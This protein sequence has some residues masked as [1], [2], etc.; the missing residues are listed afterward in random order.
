MKKSILVATIL[1]FCLVC[2]AIPLT[3]GLLVKNKINTTKPDVNI[4]PNKNTKV[5]VSARQYLNSWLNKEEKGVNLD[6]MK[7]ASEKLRSYFKNLQ[8]IK[9][10][11]KDAELLS[12]IEA[13]QLDIEAELDWLKY[14]IKTMKISERPESP[15]ILGKPIDKK[16][17]V[18]KDGGDSLD[19]YQ[20]EYNALATIG[21]HLKKYGNLRWAQSVKATYN[22][23]T[24]IELL[25][26]GCWG[27][28]LP[29]SPLILEIRLDLYDE[30][31]TIRTMIK[32][33]GEIPENPE[34]AKWIIFDFEDVFLPPNKVFYIVVWTPQPEDEIGPHYHWWIHLNKYDDGKDRYPRGQAFFACGGES[35]E[36]EKGDLCFKTYGKDTWTDTWTYYPT[37]GDKYKHKEG[38]SYVDAY[39]WPHGETEPGIAGSYAETNLW[40]KAKA[41][42]YLYFEGKANRDF[43]A[44]ITFEGWYEPMWFVWGYKGLWSGHLR[45]CWYI[46]DLTNQESLKVSFKHHDIDP[47]GLPPYTTMSHFND[48]F[49]P[50]AFNYA[51]KE[52]HYYHIGVYLETYTEA[53]GVASGYINCAKDT[54]GYPCKWSLGRIIIEEN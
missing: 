18:A 29:S 11:T 19:Q 21:R 37:K 38:W 49:S 2:A 7:R 12:K 32:E 3:T 51:F 16:M 41:I 5:F 50:C 22:I 42:S 27:K 44:D 46:V 1:S 9:E 20:T 10:K 24:R 36:E 14:A 31:S 48:T 39:A 6:E 25:M 4:E 52:K 45:I 30:S 17:S 35:W 47:P 53:L 28:P 15:I 43:T 8:L 54:K 34:D 26:S 33:R 23:L 40:G 13:L